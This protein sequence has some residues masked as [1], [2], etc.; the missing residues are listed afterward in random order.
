MAVVGATAM[1]WVVEAGSAA[2]SE[3]YT[4]VAAVIPLRAHHYCT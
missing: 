2:G 4:V 3:I 1:G